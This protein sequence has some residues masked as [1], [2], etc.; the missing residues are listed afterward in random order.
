[1]LMNYCKS[2][3]I[4]IFLAFMKWGNLFTLT[5]IQ[6]E[7]QNI[8][9]IVGSNFKM[10]KFQQFKYLSVTKTDNIVMS[11]KKGFLILAFGLRITVTLLLITF[12]V[13]RLQLNF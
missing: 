10:E 2:L 7:A 1:M 3:N 6:I 13:E 5:Y 9:S 11:F 8:A 12:Q 4:M